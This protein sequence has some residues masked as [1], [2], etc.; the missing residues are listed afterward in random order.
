MGTSKGEANQDTSNNTYCF[1]HANL[2]CTLYSLILQYGTAIYRISLKFIY[3]HTDISGFVIIF[4]FFLFLFYS[5]YDIHTGNNN[6]TNT[7]S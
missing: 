7:S 5:A 2:Y 1:Y 4:C 3:R 6:F